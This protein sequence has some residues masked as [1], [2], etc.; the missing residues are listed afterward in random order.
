VTRHAAIVWRRVDLPG[1]DSATLS[2]SPHGWELS[3]AAVLAHDGLPCRLDYHVLCDAA[4][5]TTRCDLVGH[6]GLRPVEMTISRSANTGIWE[7]NGVAAADVLEC[8][9]IDLGFTPATNLLPIRR[10]NLAIGATAAV[11]AAWVRFPELTLEVLPQTYARLASDRYLYESANGAFRRELAVNDDG[12]VAT[13][14]DYW[15]AE[16][17]TNA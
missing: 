3:G 9:D 4:W 11:R 5:R 8:E 10:L 1:H 12:F 16:A 13:Y 2:V 14:P 17:Y 6:I 15:V 7:V